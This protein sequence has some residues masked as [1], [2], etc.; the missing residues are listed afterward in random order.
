MIYGAGKGVPKDYMQAYRWINLAAIQGLESAREQLGKV[1][2]LMTKEQI[3][4]AEK[5]SKEFKVKTLTIKK[6]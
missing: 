2:E 1:S 3:N 5:F 4:D 6:P